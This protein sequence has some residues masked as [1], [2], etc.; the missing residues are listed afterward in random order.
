[1]KAK[2]CSFFFLLCI[3]LLSCGCGEQPSPDTTPDTP[4]GSTSDKPEPGTPSDYYPLAAG[5]YWIYEG[6]GNEYASFTR[7]VEYTRDNLAQLS[8]NNGG[9]V[10]TTVLSREDTGITRVFFEPE[11]YH[12]GNLLEANFTPNDQTVLLQYPL[13]IGATWTSGDC[14]KIVEATDVEVATP[15]GV[16]EQC[17]K[18]RLTWPQSNGYEY[19]KVGIG[20][21]K[22]EFLMEE[23]TISSTLKEYHLTE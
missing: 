9:T 21:V 1:M 14:E 4:P 18:I 16:F 23:G 10:I 12:P 20:M 6:Y 15:A 5:N 13:V 8:E 22:Q 11:S 3:L 2:Y 7:K 17:A 19:Y